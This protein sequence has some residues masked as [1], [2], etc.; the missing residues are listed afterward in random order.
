[1]TRKALHWPLTVMEPAVRYYEGLASRW[2][3]KYRQPAFRA[4]EEMILSCW[5]DLGLAGHW[6][7]AGCG[8]GRLSRMLAK[9]GCLVRAVDA[10]ASMT[11]LA[12][13]EAEAAGISH[14][15]VVEWVNTIESLPFASGVFDGILCSSVLEYLPDP[16]RCLSE[17]SRVL[18]PGGGLVL[19][20]PNR[21]SVL[22]RLLVA[23]CGLSGHFLVQPW[24]ACL[25]YSRNEYSR[26]GFLQLMARHGFVMSKTVFFGG[27]LPSWLRRL[28]PGGT[29]IL[30]V[31][32]KAGQ[33]EATEI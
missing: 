4:R 28:E 21:G 16:E 11:A 6:L 12:A 8:S 32:R 20:V 23:L 15:L 26:A 25:K 30:G 29:L 33:Q 9:A 19:S 2:E 14:S 31:G 24:P 27:P 22:R 17:F 10:S 18:R 7:D 1:V 13:G 5:Q 3:G